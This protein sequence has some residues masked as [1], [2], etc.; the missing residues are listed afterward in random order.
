MLDINIEDYK[1][2]EK[3]IVINS[4]SIKQKDHSYNIIKCYQNL[5][6]I[7]IFECKGIDTIKIHKTFY[8]NLSNLIQIDLSQN[9]LSKVSKNFKIFKNLE[10]LKLDDNQ[11]IF[12]PS[13]ISEFLKLKV[14]TISNNYLT[15]IPSSIQYVTTLQTLKFSNNKIIN[16]PIEFGL[17]KSL[18]I[19]HMDGNYFT[20]I[21]TTLCYLRHL[22]ELSFEWLEFLNLNKNLKE[23]MGKEWINIIRDSLQEMIKSQILYCDFVTFIEKISANINKKKKI[24]I[25]T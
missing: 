12:I 22:I 5:S 17:L 1:I 7:E 15:T 11:I 18:E 9:K 20:E 19:L 2:S 13:F 3:K 24:I 14:F 23:T 16:L 4:R 8:H 6:E 21:P 25:I 10:V